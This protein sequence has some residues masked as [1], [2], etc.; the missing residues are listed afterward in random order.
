M[1]GK[2]GTRRKKNE[3]PVKKRVAV[4][5]A[6]GSVGTSV[7]DVCRHHRDR[8]E[9]VALAAAQNAEKLASL[10]VEFGTSKLCLAS[11]EAAASLAGKLSSPVKVLS[12]PSGL[13][14]L[15]QDPNIDHIVF[16]SSGTAAIEALQTALINKKEISLANK[17]SIVVAGPWVIPLVRGRDQLR[18][19]DSEHNAIWQCLQGEKEKPRKIYLTASGGPFRDWPL[20][21]LKNATPEM[22]LKHPVWNMGAKITVD[23]ATL[24]NK[25]IELIEAMFLFGLA[26][27]QVEALISPGSFVHGLA[28]FEDGCVKILAGEPDM[29]LPAA[30]CLFWPERLRP[31]HDFPCPELSARTLSFDLPD[32]RRFPALRI[33]KE[34]LKWGGPYPALLVGADEVAVDRF[35]KKDIPFTA[36]PQVVEKTLSAYPA[37]PP[38][39]LEEALS[40][41]AWGRKHCALICGGIR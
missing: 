33:A 14:T 11:K 35:I 41:M 13:E 25:G 5:G 2:I 8:V 38:Y 12:G 1:K 7:L 32:E 17:E 37:G 9:V 4:I 36:I 39:S 20:E 16:A 10:A 40:I 23:S 6:T 19:L 31:K 15:S 28:E 21:D 18:P 26:P 3:D 29:R 30:S 24:M 27:Y 22:A 34:A